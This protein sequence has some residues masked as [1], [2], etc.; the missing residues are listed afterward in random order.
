M[1]I[2]SGDIISIRH[3]SETEPLRCIVHEVIDENVEIKPIKDFVVHNFYKHDPVVIAYE[4]NGQIYIGSG[5]IFDINTQNG[6][7]CI[8]TSS[9][10]GIEISKKIDKYPVSLLSDIRQKNSQKKESA[11]V[12]MIGLESIIFNSKADLQ[13]DD[14]V[15]IDIY[16]GKVLTCLKGEVLWKVCRS[17]NNEYCIKSFF[18]SLQTRNHVKRFL[19][20]LNEEHIE[21]MTE[22]KSL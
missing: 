21:F 2:N 14:E 12:K 13:I 6:F 11:L 15:E 9:F 18:P 20:T 4:N 8:E 22:L 7:I 1:D 5:R 19:Q 16:F 17:L 10:E 3:C